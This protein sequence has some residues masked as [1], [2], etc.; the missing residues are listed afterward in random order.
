MSTNVPATIW[1]GGDGTEY[2]NTGVNNIADTAGELFVDTVGIEVV[3]TGVTV[4]PVPASI[5][6]E[7]DSI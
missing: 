5:W 2:A 6:S 3:D 4:T 1:Q 7:D